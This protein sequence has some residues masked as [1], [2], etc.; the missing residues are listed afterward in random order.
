MSNC[1]DR[2]GFKEE[3]VHDL[4]EDVIGDTEN[5]PPCDWCGCKDEPDYYYDFGKRLWVIS[6]PCCDREVRGETEKIAMMRWR[7]E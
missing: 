6:C 2:E 7:G 5:V 3:A 4:E 1:Y